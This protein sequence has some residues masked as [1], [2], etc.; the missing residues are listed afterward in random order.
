MGK[1]ITLAQAIYQ[2][3]RIV[4]FYC[5]AKVERGWR[6]HNGAARLIEMID[7]FGPRTRLD[8][9]PARCT[10]CGRRDC[11]EVRARPHHGTLGGL[12]IDDNPESDGLPYGNEHLWWLRGG[13]D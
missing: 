12:P 4:T 9:L 7:S 8:D 5:E 2:G 1:K 3:D 13:A 6:H 10:K 11:V